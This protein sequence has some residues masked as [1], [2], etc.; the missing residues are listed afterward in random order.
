MCSDTLKLLLGNVSDDEL[1][2]ILLENEKFVLEGTLIDAIQN[3]T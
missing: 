1:S 2:K 3:K